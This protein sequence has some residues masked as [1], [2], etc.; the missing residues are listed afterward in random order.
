MKRITIL[1]LMIFLTSAVSLQAQRIA[2]VD[3]GQI[4]ETSSD[5]KAAQEELDK[6]AARWRQEIAQ[7]YDVIK[8]MYNKYQA[9]QVLMSDDMRKEKEEEIMKKEKEVRELQKAR[10][11]PEGSLFRKRQ[12]LVE[13]IQQKVYGAVEEFASKKGFDFVFDKSSST[14]ILFSNP[15][16]DKTEDVLRMLRGE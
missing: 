10:F 13:P 1:A 4:L 14:G 2:V 3:L 16:F 11:G 9:E 15:D 8:G 5:Y 7:E 12:D 6:I